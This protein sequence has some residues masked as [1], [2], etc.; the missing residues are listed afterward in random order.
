MLG[1]NYFPILKHILFQLNDSK[2]KVAESFLRITK[3]FWDFNLADL[4]NKIIHSRTFPLKEDQKTLKNY[5]LKP[6]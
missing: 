1:E 5:P 3:F 2:P 4:S 6:N